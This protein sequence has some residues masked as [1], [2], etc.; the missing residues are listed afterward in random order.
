VIPELVKVAGAR[1]GKAAK[2]RLSALSI[3]LTV[4]DEAIKAHR[5]EVGS[6]RAEYSKLNKVL[7]QRL[8]AESPQKSIWD[9]T[10]G[11]V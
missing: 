6:L 11:V 9:R 1:G 2:A 10:R 7:A 3:E 8:L 4:R 5:G